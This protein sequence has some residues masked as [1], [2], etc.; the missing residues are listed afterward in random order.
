MGNL[1]A[2]EIINLTS[3]AGYNLQHLIK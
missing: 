1:E 2:D 3:A